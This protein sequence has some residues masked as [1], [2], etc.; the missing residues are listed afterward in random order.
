MADVAVTPP[1][2]AAVN[3]KDTPEFKEALA[4][5][6]EVHRLNLE[7]EY[8]R[9]QQEWEAQHRPVAPPA[10]NGADYFEVWGEKHGLPAQAGRELVE[11]VV[12]YMTGQVLPAVIKPLSQSAKRQELRSQ[13]AELRSSNAKLAKLDDR[14]H[15]E[16]MKLLDPMDAS[17][18]GAD[19]YARALY[20]VIGQNIDVIEAE[21]EKAGTEKA[22]RQSEVAPGPEPLPTSE[23][24][25]PSKV[26]L[27]A[28]QQQFCEDKGF[29][30]EDFVE[31]MRDRA[32]KLEANGMTKVQ[33]RG[34]LGDM[35]G[36]IEF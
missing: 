21:R 18:V 29:S 1:A 6:R 10:G 16:V 28:K 26:V 2:A 31:M 27:N 30:A 23:S 32:R 17:L 11:G 35:L 8:R 4:Q 25:K 20:M 13:R 7:A 3:V 9:K 12:G 36:G 15:A 34:R 5:E 14:F 33:V 22:A 24:G 19:S